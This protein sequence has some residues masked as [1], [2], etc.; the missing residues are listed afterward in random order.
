MPAR[1]SSPTTRLVDIIC[2]LTRPGGGVPPEFGPTSAGVSKSHGL[3]FAAAGTAAAGVGGGAG[4]LSL[5]HAAESALIIIRPA[6]VSLLM[7]AGRIPPAFL[8]VSVRN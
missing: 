5:P 7:V 8:N 3:R 2:S 4:G 6:S 1:A